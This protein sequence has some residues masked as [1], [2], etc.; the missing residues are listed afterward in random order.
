MDDAT[1]P[2]NA[3][4]KSRKIHANAANLIA[5]AEQALAVNNTNY[6]VS[7]G[8]MRQRVVMITRERR[9][10]LRAQSRSFSALKPLIDK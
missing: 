4:P 7:T 1:L 2:A 6:T 5:I 10:M 3:E 9:N 8:I